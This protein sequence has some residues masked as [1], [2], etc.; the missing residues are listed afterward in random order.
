MGAAALL[1]AA[2]QHLGIAIQEQHT[3]LVHRRGEDG[4]YRLQLLKQRTGA[5]VG[6]Q[7]D[8]RQRL[9]ALS[10]QLQEGRHQGGGHIIDAIVADVLQRLAGQGFAGAGHTGDDNEFHSVFLSFTN[11][12]RENVG[13]NTVRPYGVGVN[14]CEP[15]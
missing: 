3:A 5:Y 6:Y 1:K 12:D 4:Q 15:R 14:G 8:A 2:A 13:V 7:R 11:L 10:A 9:T